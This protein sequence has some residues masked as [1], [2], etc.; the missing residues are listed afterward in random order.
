MA[1][2]HRSFPSLCVSFTVSHIGVNGFVTVR[3]RLCDCVDALLVIS[4]LLHSYFVS[5]SALS[6]TGNTCDLLFTRCAC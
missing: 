1:C 4:I 3:Q 5:R 6:V 2:S